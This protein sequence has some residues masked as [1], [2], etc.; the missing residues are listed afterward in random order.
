MFRLQM[1]RDPL[2]DPTAPPPGYQPLDNHEPFDQLPTLP[3]GVW[4]FHWSDGRDGASFSSAAR[5]A[6]RMVPDIHRLFIRS[7]WTYAGCLG[8]REW[9]ERPARASGLSVFR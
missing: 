1:T 7:G 5:L 8:G 3:D 4:W 9:Y 6:G 2:P